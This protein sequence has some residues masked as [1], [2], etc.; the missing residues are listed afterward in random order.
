MNV[1]IKTKIKPIMAPPKVKTK[2][3]SS[4]QVNKALAT[5]SN[6]MMKLLLIVPFTVMVCSAPITSASYTFS[7]FDVNDLFLKKG[8]VEFIRVIFKKSIKYK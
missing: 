4:D 7:L 2:L 6:N 8:L 1:A 5:K 3:F